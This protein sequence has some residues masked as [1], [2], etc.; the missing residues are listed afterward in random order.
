MTVAF[1]L[2]LIEQKFM[3]FLHI[4]HFVRPLLCFK[5]IASLP[6]SHDIYEEIRDLSDSSSMQPIIYQHFQRG[7]R[8][9]TR[10]LIVTIIT[11]NLDIVGC[12]ISFT[13]VHSNQNADILYG[14][15]A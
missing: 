3:I 10:Y 2:L 6:R 15:V 13:V 9:L 7:N 5:L 12:I 11:S 1:I 4:L 14:F 8:F